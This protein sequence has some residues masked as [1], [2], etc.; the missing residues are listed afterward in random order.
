MCSTRPLSDQVQSSVLAHLLATVS[1]PPFQLPIC[2]MCFT[3]LQVHTYTYIIPS[4]G[5]YPVT[6]FVIMKYWVLIKLEIDIV[7]VRGNP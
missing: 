6:F 7:Y 1:Q 2:G 4:Y 5:F 3:H